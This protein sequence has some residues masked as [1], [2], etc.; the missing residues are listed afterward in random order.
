MKHV[1]F[2][3]THHNAFAIFDTKLSDYRIT[4]PDVP[5]HNNTRSNVVREVFNAFRK[6]DFAIGVYFPK[7]DWHRPDY[8]DPSAPARSRNPNYDTLAEP[9]EWQRIVRFGH[10]Q[11]EELMTGYG[12]I[13]I[14]CGR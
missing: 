2:T 9:E 8:W 5:F 6:E 3:T 1:V 10:G 13:D 14:P 11:I 7:P 4:A 12:P